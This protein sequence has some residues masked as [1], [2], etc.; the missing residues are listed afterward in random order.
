[1]ALLVDGRDVPVV[2]YLVA[3]PI[4][5][6]GWEGGQSTVEIVHRKSGLPTAIE[7]ITL[8]AIIHARSNPPMPNTTIR[9]GVP[10]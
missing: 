10:A 3:V 2:V 5:G 9:R 6:L 7:E 1:M 4:I 8:A